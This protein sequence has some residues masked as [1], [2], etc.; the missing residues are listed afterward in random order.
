MDI[1]ALNKITYG[2]FVLTAWD[3]EGKVNGCIV[4]TVMQVTVSPNTVAVAVNKQNLTH[5]MIMDSKEFTASVISEKADFEMF[6]RFGL[7]SGRDVNKFEGYE[8]T[9]KDSEGGIYVT[10][11]ANAYVHGK[12]IN[13]VDLGTHTMFIAE[14]VDANIL[15]N[16]PSMTYSYYHENVKPKPVID[17]AAEGEEKV[18]GKWVCKICGYVYEGQDLPEDFI[19]PWCKHPASDFEY[20]T[21]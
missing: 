1:L 4:N 6:K 11:A 3:K 7:Q 16:D 8:F 19:C 9:A 5:D 20:V 17:K 12:V 15:N 21:A 18:E 10:E 2:L 14:L 13:T